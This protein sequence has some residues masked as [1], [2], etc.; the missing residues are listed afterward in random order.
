[1][2]RKNII[3]ECANCRTPFSVAESIFNKRGTVKYCSV[4]CR[5]LG[6]RDRI[7]M[8]CR[9]CGVTFLV[10]PSVFIR[11]GTVQFCSK[12]CRLIGTKASDPASRLEYIVDENGC[13]IWQKGFDEDGYGKLVDKR[14]KGTT[15]RAHRVSYEKFKG[16]IPEGLILDHLCRN[17]PC[18]NPDHLEPVT[19]SIN[20]RRGIGFAA[21]NA[22]K[23]HCPQGHPYEGRNLYIHPSGS[24]ICRKCNLEAQKRY[25]V[26]KVTRIAA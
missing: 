13:W 22:V 12:S 25:K 1:M 8:E 17:P 26:R 14:G 21:I 24:R 7:S 3:L 16:P 23:T 9:Q 11:R 6:R 20:S 10:K 5:N 2:T 18:I 15:V 4:A 19:H